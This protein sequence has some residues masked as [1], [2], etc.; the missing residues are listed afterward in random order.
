MNINVAEPALYDV[1][2][3][4]P[5][6]ALVVDRL[7]HA[8]RRAGRNRTSVG[9][10][11]LNLEVPAAPGESGRRA[12]AEWMVVAAA[13][14]LRHCVR[15]SDTVGR[16]GAGEF[17]VVFDDLVSADQAMGVAERVQ[18]SMSLPLVGEEGT[19][20]LEVS[21]GVVF[22]TGTSAPDDLFRD[23]DAAMYH[24]HDKGRG[25]HAFF[26]ATVREGDRACQE[27]EAGLHG[28]L[29]RGEGLRVRYQPEVEVHSGRVVGVEAS[30]RWDHPTLGPIGHESLT[31]LTERIG[32]AAPLGRFV[33]E[34]GCR[35]ATAWAAAGLDLRVT[36][37]L[38]PG[39]LVGPALAGTVAELLCRSGLSA[40]S[41]CFKVPEAALAGDDGRLALALWHLKST[42]V[43]LGVTEFGGSYSSLAQLRRFPLDEVEVDRAFLADVGQE[44]EAAPPVRAIVAAAHSLG[45][46]VA[47]A[48]I[49]HPEQFQA[50]GH[51]GF[52]RASGGYFLPAVTPVELARFLMDN[53]SP[54]WGPWG[55]S[56]AP[57]SAS[58]ANEMGRLAHSPIKNATDLSS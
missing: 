37:P 28:A 35:Q 53:G 5:N 48:G 9:V 31:V 50:L 12:P 41:L 57:E 45:L 43:R 24:A 16:F 36:V 42:G 23:A 13:E 17:I 56:K 49:E 21:V 30:C 22:G 44:A 19:M 40:A 33:L 4:L 20:A 25:C 14:R 38:S 46:L 55:R 6:R 3:G 58:T 34:D 29:I 51:L 27:M 54:P 47:A 15:S 39:Q 7:E 18:A 2:T 52:Q 10:L 8:L 11:C 1:L 26:D 32:L